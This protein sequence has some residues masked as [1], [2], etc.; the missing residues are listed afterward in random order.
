MTDNPHKSPDEDPFRKIQEE[1]MR[2]DLPDVPDDPEVEERLRRAADLP[3]ISSDD[4]LEYLSMEMQERVG[5][6]AST[7]LPPVPEFDERF[8]QLEDA[9]R[10]ARGKYDNERLEKDR[11]RRED[12]KSAAGLGYGLAIAY[13]IIGVPLLGALIGWVIDSRLGTTLWTGILTVLGAVVGI[14]YALVLINRPGAPK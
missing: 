8:R 9:S 2:M 14:G 5:D 4:D 7:E 1:L 12:A 3:P 6:A 10:Q 11:I 13:A